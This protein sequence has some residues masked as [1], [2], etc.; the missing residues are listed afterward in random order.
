MMRSFC[1]CSWPFG[2]SFS[3]LRKFQKEQLFFP[4]SKGMLLSSKRCPFADSPQIG[5]F[6]IW[7]AAGFNSL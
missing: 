7:H 6:Y 3:C 2:V 1:I 5:V 4:F